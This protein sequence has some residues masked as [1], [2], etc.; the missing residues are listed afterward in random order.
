M[1]E[2]EAK[3]E[4][5]KPTGSG[6][7]TKPLGYWIVKIVL[8][9]S[10]AVLGG[11]ELFTEASVSTVLVAILASLAGGPEIVQFIRKDPK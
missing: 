6:E 3:A 2:S 4:S 8:G 11:L 7:E 10:I 1:A 5:Q 9:L